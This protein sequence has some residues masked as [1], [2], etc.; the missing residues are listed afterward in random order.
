MI[1]KGFADRTRGTERKERDGIS[2]TVMDG[3]P[4]P[5]KVNLSAVHIFGRCAFAPFGIVLRL[6]AKT[7]C[8]VRRLYSA[9]KHTYRFKSRSTCLYTSSMYI[10]FILQVKKVLAARWENVITQSNICRCHTGFPF[11]QE[12]AIYLFIFWR[13]KT[14]QQIV[15]PL[16]VNMQ[17]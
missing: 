13:S 6:K 12:K 11:Y 9:R 17:K 14:T 2:K 3:T 10:F 5:F 8:L 4:V 7:R 1:P 15:L 16:L